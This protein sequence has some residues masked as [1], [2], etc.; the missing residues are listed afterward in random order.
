MNVQAFLLQ[1]DI[2]CVRIREESTISE[3]RIPVHF[4][5]VLDNS[6]SMAMENKLSHV[7]RSL[8][9]I[10]NMLTADDMVS[11]I[12]FS[13]DA[14]VVS[15]RMA[16]THDNKA[17]L[18][19]RLKDIC[20]EGST[21]ISA[22]IIK[23]RG[24]LIVG[25]GHK[26]GILLL[27]DGQA[28]FGIQD[29]DGMNGLIRTLVAEFP[30]TTINSIGYGIDH[31]SDLLRGISGEGSGSY[32][33]VENLEDVAT[34]FG[35]IL[36]GLAS[37]AYQ[38]VTVQVPE[39]SWQITQLPSDIGIVRIGDLNTQG[40]ATILLSGIHEGDEIKVQGYDI[41]GLAFVNRDVR[42]AREASDELLRHGRIAKLRIDVTTCMSMVRDI[43]MR[44]GGHGEERTRAVEQITEL[45]AKIQTE[46][47]IHG[48]SQLLNFLL[49]ELEI[50]NHTMTMDI[51]SN[52]E[53]HHATQILTQHV[54]VMTTGRG[55]S[56]GATPG[57]PSDPMPI[58]SQLQP[59]FSNNL[60][61]R[62]S[63]GLRTQASQRDEEPVLP[64]YS[65]G[66]HQIIN[67]PSR[68]TTSGGSGLSL[69]R[70]LNTN[71]VSWPDGTPSEVS[72]V[73]SED[74]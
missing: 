56:S 46:I 63:S 57:R 28:N 33:V 11:L 51:R 41:R 39:A 50:C 15:Q 14:K 37:C 1:D 55:I 21:N 58:A 71:A 64:T 30:G 49:E 44:H 61:R 13:D 67:T 4:A 17:V 35:D 68:S 69:R 47:S 38:Q 12:T 54:A 31:N 20:S 74:E 16:M 3:A 43:M 42:V 62:I 8:H 70:R 65:G 6:G 72:P 5:V 34:V 22:G 32:N 45:R 36:G 48:D 59:V 60:Q 52:Y 9:Y 2:A 18:Q 27:T 10:I 40:E 7:K 19:Q 66:L 73:D 29:V 26:Q 53:N 25:D 23:A 24:E